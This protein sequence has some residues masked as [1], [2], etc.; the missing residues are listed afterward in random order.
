M[1]LSIIQPL[2]PTGDVLPLME[3]W[4]APYDFDLKITRPRKSKLG[5]FRPPKPGPA[6]LKLPSGRKL[7]EQ[8]LEELK[9]LVVLKNQEIKDFKEKIVN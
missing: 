8:Q 4:T 3:A 1:D 6:T 2:L 7:N 5:D 9:E